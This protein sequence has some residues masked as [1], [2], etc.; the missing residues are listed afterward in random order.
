MASHQ[1]A[2]EYVQPEDSRPPYFDGKNYRH[3]KARMRAYV[4]SVDYQSW[5]IIQNGPLPIPGDEEGKEHEDEASATKPKTVKYT[6]EQRDV[7]EH[8]AR[9]KHLLNCAL[10]WEEFGKID[11]CKTAKEVWDRLEIRHEGTEKL[12]EDWMYQLIHEYETFS[13]KEDETIKDM[14]GRINKIL[15]DLEALRHSYSNYEQVRKTLRILPRVWKPFVDAIEYES[16]VQMSYDELRIKLIIYEKTYLQKHGRERK[17]LNVVFNTFFE[18]IENELHDDEESQEDLA[19]IFKG[20]D[21]IMKRRK[22]SK[23]DGRRNNKG[24]A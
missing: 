20:M 23:N 19:M 18:E 14:F 15:G 6:R 8:N 4:Q 16:L 11:S 13:M 7:I 3:W 9:A 1:F 17:R 21:N 24:S 5:L 22:P 12:K 10:S 2:E